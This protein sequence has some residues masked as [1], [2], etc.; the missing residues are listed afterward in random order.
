MNVFTP[1]APL[2]T[3]V[4]FLVFNRPVTTEQVFKAIR[5][6]RPPRLYVAADGPR[7]G[8]DGEAELVARVREI[9][10][11]VDWA[12]EVK[13]LFREKNLGC[14]YA[15]SGAI[16]WFF[17]QEEQGIILEDDCL[18]SQSFF[19]FCEE[20]LNFYSKDSRV[21]QISGFNFANQWQK[22]NADYFFATGGS[23]WGWATWRRVAENF[24]SFYKEPSKPLLLAIS[25]F[26]DDPI[27]SR[28][29]YE[30]MIEVHSGR[31]DTWDYNWSAMLQ[32]NSQM[33]IVPK[34][35][36]VINIGFGQDATHTISDS[37]YN[38]TLN[39]F[40]IRDMMH[41]EYIYADKQFSKKQA[42]T[43]S[44]KEKIIFLIKSLLNWN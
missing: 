42:G 8:R 32:A 23:I 44:L 18:P 11:D 24:N 34:K 7:E 37:Q 19:W 43:L 1:P 38:V 6:A 28:R 3:S 30:K 25:G 4:L 29:F 5:Q 20:L 41:P 9:A 22:N 33:S 15:V 2:N 12:C 36:M 26:T 13:T 14:K 16:T 35:N 39:D 21:G 10:T 40:D 31:L 17:E 27:V